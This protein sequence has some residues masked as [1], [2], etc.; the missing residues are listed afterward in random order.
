MLLLLGHL[1]WVNKRHR[2]SWAQASDRTGRLNDKVCFMIS[3]MEHKF[4]KQHSTPL[5]GHGCRE[6]LH[7]RIYKEQAH[8]LSMIYALMQLHY[9]HN[10]SPTVDFNWDPSLTGQV[11]YNYTIEL[12]YLSLVLTVFM[13]AIEDITPSKVHATCRALFSKPLFGNFGLGAVHAIDWEL[14]NLSWAPDSQ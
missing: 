8:G 9:W 1:F 6:T 13:V 12:L 14:S 7:S 10:S 11:Y 4:H 2:F 3:V 5:Q